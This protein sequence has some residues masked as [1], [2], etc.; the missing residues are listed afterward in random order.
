MLQLVNAEEGI[1]NS[2]STL[3]AFLSSVDTLHADGSYAAYAFAALKGTCAGPRWSG[4]GAQLS[5]HRLTA[6]T[7][8]CHAAPGASSAL[9]GGERSTEAP[10]HGCRL[11]QRSPQFCSMRV[12]L[13]CMGSDSG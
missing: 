8:P 7:A 10:S 1:D 9:H 2:E 4:T 6:C 3:R 12:H 13:A 5:H 11:Q